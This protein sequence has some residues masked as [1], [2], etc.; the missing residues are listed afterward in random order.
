MSD[1]SAPTPAAEPQSTPAPRFYKIR[2]ALG[3][4]PEPSGRPPFIWVERWNAFIIGIA[5]AL[6]VPLLGWSGIDYETKKII[7]IWWLAIWLIFFSYF[8]GRELIGQMIGRGAIKQE[9][10]SEQQ[11]TAQ[12]PFYGTIFAVVIYVVVLAVHVARMPVADGSGVQYFGNIV[13]NVWT[14]LWSTPMYYGFVEWF[15]IIH[16]WVCTSLVNYITYNTGNTFSKAAPMGERIE[17]RAPH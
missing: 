5:V 12:D 6:G 14:G 1:T 2:V 9:Q 15:I 17:R 4:L 7:L 10:L 13:R 11:N 16:T 3:M 8:E